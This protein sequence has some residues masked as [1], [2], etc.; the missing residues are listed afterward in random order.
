MK[1]RSIYLFLGIVSYV[2]AIAEQLLNLGILTSIYSVINQ[3]TVF[4][5]L[6][7]IGTA[8][9][10]V[11]LVEAIRKPKG[12]IFFGK[13]RRRPASASLYKPYTGKDFGVKWLL[14][15]PEPLSK[16]LQPWADGPYCPKCDRELEEETIGRFRKQTVWI[17]PICGREYPMPKGDAKDIVEKNFAAYLR[18]KG[19]L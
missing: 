17:C 5:I 1:L 2:L 19:E 18:K 14:Y 7:I 4:Y 15:P 16:N 12:N 10:V 3:T 8:F 9:V 6:V 13:I 11:Y